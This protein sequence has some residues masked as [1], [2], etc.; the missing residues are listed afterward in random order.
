MTTTYPPFIKTGRAAFS[1]AIRPLIAKAKA[2]PVPQNARCSA[3]LN[4]DTVVISASEADVTAHG[5]T[6]KDLNQHA[7]FIARRDSDGV[8][9]EV[10][11]IK[12]SLGGCMYDHHYYLISPEDARAEWLR[13]K[14][15][16]YHV[17]LYPLVTKIVVDQFSR[18]SFCKA[19]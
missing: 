5:L 14:G 3:D 9:K 7:S 8:T 1:A 19:A 6:S 2:T 16:G 15:D 12:S 17:T 13:L 4:N 18:I 10:W 11:L